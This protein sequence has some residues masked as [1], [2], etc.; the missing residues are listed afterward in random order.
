MGQV[1]QFG[2]GISTTLG[3][4]TTLDMTPIVWLAYNTSH[5]LIHS[6]Y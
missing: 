1:E 2:H 6:Y 4:L 5:K 3:K